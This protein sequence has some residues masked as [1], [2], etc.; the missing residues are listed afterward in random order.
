MTV[1][2]L[3]AAYTE[4]RGTVG[5]GSQ[6]ERPLKC[7]HTSGDWRGETMA[8]EIGRPD[9]REHLILG[10]GVRSN[11]KPERPTGSLTHHPPAPFDLC[12]KN[13]DRRDC[14]SEIDAGGRAGGKGYD[15]R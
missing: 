4:K 12:Q 15:R 2:A 8:N 9:C 7:Y 10:R 3:I 5:A 11:Y 13:A 6:P 14:E 1:A